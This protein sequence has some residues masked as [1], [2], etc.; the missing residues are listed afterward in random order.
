M[1]ALLPRYGYKE[2]NLFTGVL[3][4]HTIVVRKSNFTKED[5]LEEHFRIDEHF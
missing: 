3:E 2:R 5:S 4:R 1:M